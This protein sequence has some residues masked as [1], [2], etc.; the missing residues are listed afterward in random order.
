MSWVYIPKDQ[1]LESYLYSL[2]QEADCL[3]ASGSKAG[4]PSVTLNGTN[5]ANGSS[6]PESGTGCS[7]MRPSGTTST[8]STVNRGKDLLMSSAQGFRV[9]RSARQ[10]IKN[11]TMIAETDGLTPFALLEKFSPD[12][13]FS[14][15]SEG[16][17]PQWTRPQMNLFRT[18]EPYYETFPKAGM[19]RNGVCYPQPSAERRISVI[20]SGLWPTPT[21]TERAT[22]GSG[23][24][25]ITQN[26][27]VRRR[28][29]DGTSSNMGLEATVKMWPTPTASGNYN[30]EGAQCKEW[31]GLVTAVM[32]YA[33][34]QARDYRTG[35]RSRWENP[36]RSRNL[37]DQVGGKLNPN[38]VD[39]L[40]GFPVG[41]TDLKPLAT[42]KFRQWLQ[43][44][45]VC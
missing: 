45:G 1:N 44:H 30:P 38:W 19:M 33:T 39:W 29:T 36:E 37:N 6:K 4:E 18:S 27:T 11:Q 34:P 28:N 42:D 40:M 8:R 14:K 25:Y 43:Q 15:T 9:S 17:Y 2:A 26:G 3:Q 7:T 16:Y 5:T 24:L 20:E 32:K 41:W 35:Q 13:S 31:G 10:G 23:T 21:S 12:T 22:A